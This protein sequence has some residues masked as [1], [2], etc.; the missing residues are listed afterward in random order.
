MSLGPQPITTLRTAVWAMS[1]LATFVDRP[2]VRDDACSVGI[3]WSRAAGHGRFITMSCNP[4]QAQVCM[5]DPCPEKSLC[6]ALLPRRCYYLYLTV[7][8]DVMY[9]C[10]FDRELPA[11]N[12][13]QYVLYIVSHFIIFLLMSF[14]QVNILNFSTFSSSMYLD[15]C[16]IANIMLQLPSCRPRKVNT[17]TLHNTWFSISNLYIYNAH[18]V[19][20]LL[21]CSHS[22]LYCHIKFS[23]VSHIQ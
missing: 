22:L 4:T 8:E 19:H 5:H 11:P 15:M 16:F 2:R 10:K 14:M 18:P 9:D 21:F 3:H 17:T 13:I 1:Q 6:S 7:K 12:I 20:P 23:H